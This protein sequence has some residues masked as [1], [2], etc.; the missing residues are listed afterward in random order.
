MMLPL[1]HDLT[2]EQQDRVVAALGEA[3]AAAGSLAR[4]DV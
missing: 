1:F 3:L 4:S 2:V